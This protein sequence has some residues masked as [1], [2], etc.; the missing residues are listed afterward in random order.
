MRLTSEKVTVVK[1]L[2]GVRKD[3]FVLA[4]ALFYSLN[5]FCSS[6][7]INVLW[8]SCASHWLTDFSTYGLLLFRTANLE[9]QSLISKPRCFRSVLITAWKI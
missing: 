1:T 5:T 9:S 2:S 6:L 4:I 3:P 7:L 8:L